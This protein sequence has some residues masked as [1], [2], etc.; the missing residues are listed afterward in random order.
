MVASTNKRLADLVSEGRF[1]DDLY[2]RLSVV[3]LSIPPLV[4]RRED[5]PYLVEHFVQRFNAKR[6]KQ[7]GGVTPAVMAIL[8]R[9]DFPGNARELENIIEYG[10]VLCHDRLIDVGHLPEELQAGRHDAHAAPAAASRL[11]WAEADAIR[12]AIARADGVLGRAADELGIDRTT[13]WR[14]MKRYGLTAD[15]GGR[16]PAPDRGR[17]R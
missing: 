4:E 9:H 10:F 3:R 1:R 12:A 16:A 6:G 17:R 8:M 5:I 15:P 7:I 11:Q 2:F 13:L 14:K